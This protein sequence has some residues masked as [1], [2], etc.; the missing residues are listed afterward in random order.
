MSHEIYYTSAP[1]GIL[2]GS[3]GFCVVASTPNPPQPLLDALTSLSSYREMFSLHDPLASQN[4]VNYSHLTI[5]VGPKTYHILSR[6]C[7]AGADYT[8]RTN[9][10]AHH[11][12]LEATE[13]P[14]QSPAWI[15]SQPQAMATHFQG[16]P[17]WLPANRLLPVG[18][19]Q[20]QVCR[21]WQQ[22][23]GDAGWAGVLVERF[24][25]QPQ[26]PTHLIVPLGLDTLG[27]FQEAAALLPQAQRWRVSFSTYFTKLPPGVNC[28]WRS[29]VEGT[30]EAKSIAQTYPNSVIDL[31]RPLPA[32]SGGEYVSAA[33]S[34]QPHARTV[35][36]VAPAPISSGPSLAPNPVPTQQPPSSYQSVPPPLEQPPELGSPV[37][38]QQRLAVLAFAGV[39]MLGLLVGG[40]WIGT[41][42]ILAQNSAEPEPDRLENRKTIPPPF[43]RRQPREQPPRTTGK[44]TQQD[45]D[46]EPD[47]NRVRF[48]DSTGKSEPNTKSKTEPNDA[49]P[50]VEKPQPDPK[51]MPEPPKPTLDDWFAELPEHLSLPFPPGNKPY[52]LLLSNEVDLTAHGLEIKLETLFEVKKLEIQPIAKHT[53]RVV[54][55]D[56]M[57]SQPIAK[58]RLTPEAVQLDWNPISKSKEA[59]PIPKIETEDDY[60]QR[61]GYLSCSWLT[62]RRSGSQDSGKRIQLF[63]PAELPTFRIENIETLEQATHPV[64]ENLPVEI[65]RMQTFL[66]RQ[67]LI[68]PTWQ[69]LRNEQYQNH[70]YWEAPLYTDSGEV[71]PAIRLSI[72]PVKKSS[73]QLGSQFQLMRSH[74]YLWYSLQRGGVKWNEGY[75]PQGKSFQKVSEDFQTLEPD[76][77]N[78]NWKRLKRY[79]EGLKQFFQ[80][81]VT[82]K[83]ISYRY[84]I[85]QKDH[86]EPFVL[87]KAPKA[88]EEKPQ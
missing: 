45:D 79:V 72:Q 38:Q 42:G 11:W 81:D 16:E 2:P 67:G 77:D 27:L 36:T 13:L 20:A 71:G 19:D 31:T 69:V 46:S 80:S 4:P 41:S 88:Q 22:A 29:V 26:Q 78:M 57:T 52:N 60:L 59:D 58:L 23:T 76:A 63:E 65:G 3:Q 47:K 14:A 30:P 17:T 48:E 21:C 51:P 18:V 85:E 40:I 64:V 83:P 54:L 39:L 50:D 25:S 35:E 43:P 33:R 12:A 37:A 10:F 55:L 6:V 32:A 49:K 84:A 74:H 66:D 82:F 53:Y 15:L 68:E 87:I 73:E 56:S 75:L 7:F 62:V 8:H 70:R 61:W 24:L 5:G 86:P 28:H 1:R 44:S 9:L 34:G